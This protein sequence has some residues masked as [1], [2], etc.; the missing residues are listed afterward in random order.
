MQVSYDPDLLQH[1]AI[2]LRYRGKFS[3][4]LYT[5]DSGSI[6]SQQSCVVWATMLES[7]FHAAEL[8]AAADAESRQ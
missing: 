2:F 8:Q 3:N 5:Y 1:E 4:E 6:R 7:A